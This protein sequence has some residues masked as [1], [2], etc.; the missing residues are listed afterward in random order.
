M[1]ILEGDEGEAKEGTWIK[2]FNPNKLLTRLFALLA[3][4]KAGTYSYKLKVEIRQ[5]LYLL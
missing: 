1:P 2:I 4:R 3:Q 5:I